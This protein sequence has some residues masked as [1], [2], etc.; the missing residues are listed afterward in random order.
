MTVR[1]DAAVIAPGRPHITLGGTE[2][3]EEGERE[4][5]KGEGKQSEGEGE[6]APELTGRV[7]EKERDKNAV[8]DRNR[9]TGKTGRPLRVVN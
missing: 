9:A 1:E 5:R 3:P 6:S 4:G 7:T 2:D 8:T